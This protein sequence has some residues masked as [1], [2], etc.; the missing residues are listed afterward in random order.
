MKPRRDS[1]AILTAVL[2]S[3][4]YATGGGVMIEGLEEREMAN[5]D[6]ADLSSNRLSSSWCNSKQ[7]SYAAGILS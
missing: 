7:A 5:R 2:D 6:G 1:G 4:K 3:L